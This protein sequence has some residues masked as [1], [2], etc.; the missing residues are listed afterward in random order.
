ME[1][2][3]T[4][5]L[6]GSANVRYRERR[7]NWIC[8][9]CDHVFVLGQPSAR[10]KVFISYGHDYT[11]FVLYLAGILQE[12]GMEVW[13]D[14]QIPEG[15]D[16]RAAITSTLLEADKVLAFLSVH[17]VRTESVCL[18]E[19]AIAVG[20]GTPVVPVLLDKDAFFSVPASINGI[21]YLDY[22]VFSR[23]FSSTASMDSVP[24]WGEA[25]DRMVA[26]LAGPVRDGQ[27]DYLRVRLNQPASS[28]RL[29]DLKRPYQK[30]AWI[31]ERISDWFGKRRRSL[32]MEAYPGAGK[33]CY[34]SHFFHY[35][36]MTACLVFCDD[37]SYGQDKVSG[38]IRRIAFS[39]AAKIPEYKSNLI[40][41][42][43]SS[44]ADINALSG[45]VLMDELLAKPLQRGIDGQHPFSLIV[46]D[47][48]DLLDEGEKNDLVG[49]CMDLSA[50]V[51][52]YIGF[53]FTARQSNAVNSFFPSEEIL[54]LRPDS[55]E[56]L[57]DIS[58]FLR[59]E[60]PDLPE[61][62]YEKL[63]RRCRGSFLYAS[64]LAGFVKEGGVDL[65]KI[66]RGTFYRLYLVSMNKVFGGMDGFTPWALAA[67]ILVAFDRI[68]VKL[69]C[70]VLN[71]NDAVFSKF[72]RKFLSLTEVSV[73]SYGEKTISFV[74]PTFRAWLSSEDH[75]Y[76]VDTEAGIGEMARL[77]E[78]TEVDSL[79]RY[80]L[81]HVKDIFSC[82]EQGYMFRCRDERLLKRLLRE[83]EECLSDPLHFFDA[84]SYFQVCEEM[85]I[86]GDEIWSI[87]SVLLPYQRS[88]KAFLSGDYQ[89]AVRLLTSLPDRMERSRMRLDS[90]YMQGTSLDIV[91]HRKE[92]AEVFLRLL[93]E[94]VAGDF[95]VKALCGLLWNDH[96]NNLESG[97]AHLER[98]KAMTDLPSSEALLRDLILA[99]H[100]LSQGKLKAS[101]DL[102]ER[103]LDLETAEIWGYDS[104]ACRN[105][106][107]FIEA[108]VACFDNNLYERGIAI[109]KAIYSRLKG[110]GN[111]AECYCCSWIAMN[112]LYDGLMEEAEEYL[113]RGKA[114]NRL[115]EGVFASDWMTMHLT[116]IEAFMEVE[117]Q[118]LARAGELHRAILRQAEACDD[119]W[120]AGDA[121]FELF[122]IEG[123]SP[124]IAHR[125]RALADSSKL[126]HLE[127]KA[128]VV[129]FFLT[130]QGREELLAETLK[131]VIGK[132][133]P[134][135]DEVKVLGL[136]L[137]M[138]AD[139]DRLALETGLRQLMVEIVTNNPEGRFLDRP[140]VKEIIKITGYER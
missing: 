23:V 68:P 103:M 62:T 108:V 135:I 25:V 42:L 92:S 57:E 21:Q 90:L 69:F 83:G 94:S 100:L 51:P 77:F 61:R 8:D 19:L 91:G 4:C 18:D 43:N 47:G 105:Q 98:L 67:S 133:L 87:R 130:G 137:P 82:D 139:A 113:A 65:E 55:R 101:L 106:M 58:G 93:D 128:D 80:Q 60:I 118:H 27:I 126:P 45:E 86:A 88:R 2:T 33:S 44:S 26:L 73:D 96:F 127:Y 121:L 75:P 10:T 14:R 134:S 24:G 12:K 20:C 85:S 110:H 17:S 37:G 54:S 46:I 30:R 22:T 70:K 64:I 11:E 136:L 102:F 15:K 120:V 114:L 117:K 9:D 5:P 107:L 1:K 97:K 140:S 109:G 123:A 50:K 116:S 138:A 104:V 125:L 115:E 13:T 59:T 119:A 39:L 41:Q 71:W 36:P 131:K 132:Q 34:C 124:S 122:C 6:C 74:Y 28:A 78:E 52:D 129:E 49:L 3:V 31:D 111:I 32:L 84:D 40:W 7:S 99:R 89:S 66:P 29:N 81:L 76:H 112:C 53:L 38:I 95:Y 48:V 16:W 72:R 56:T 63:A 79:H 35:N